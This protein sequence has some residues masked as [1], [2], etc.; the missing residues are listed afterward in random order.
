MALEKYVSPSKALSEGTH[1]KG[2]KK[3]TF[4]RDNPGGDWLK[5]HQKRA[6]EEGSN[7]HGAPRHWG[8]TTGSF[9][10]HVLM[11]VEKL[12]K[13]KG[14][15]GEQSNV[16]HDTL[17]YLKKHMGKHGTLPNSGREEDWSG[18]KEHAPFIQVSHDGKPWVSEG[19][20]RIMAAKALG[21]EHM[22]VQLQYHSGGED[23][24]GDWHPET[25]LK[26]HEE[27]RKHPRVSDKK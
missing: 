19:N 3:P 8:S 10:S 26:E 20:H 12:A 21:W 25:V 9:E 6:K 24:K 17:D 5:G 23:V 1:T 22:P 11:P 7:K 13:V 4:H 18:K 2:Y 14:I 15:M 16:R 27:L